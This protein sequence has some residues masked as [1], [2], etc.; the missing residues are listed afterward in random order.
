[1]DLIGF[2]FVEFHNTIFPWCPF[3]ILIVNI[4]QWFLENITLLI[5]SFM[6]WQ[7]DSGILSTVGHIS[8]E[9]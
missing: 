6:L 4:V 1:M 7:L 2:Q 8:Y 9:I 5:I 3:N